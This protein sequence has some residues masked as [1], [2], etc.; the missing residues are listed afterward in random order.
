MIK[1]DTK[2]KQTKY[3]LLD[4]RA[5]KEL[6]EIAGNIAGLKDVTSH[7]KRR[8]VDAL[9]YNLDLVDHEKAQIWLLAR[10]EGR[11]V[12]EFMDVV[13]TSDD[14]K[15]AVRTAFAF[16]DY[17]DVG[18]AKRIASEISAKGLSGL[19]EES[20]RFVRLHSDLFGIE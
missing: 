16:L 6:L 11:R 12:D 18:K 19:G 7:E 14:K 10:A 5:R 4:S 2:A 3:A 1:L 20:K 8:T 15:T 13:K 17:Q 9:L